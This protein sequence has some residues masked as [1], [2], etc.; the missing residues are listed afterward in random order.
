MVLKSISSPLFD[1]YFPTQII[2][3]NFYKD[4]VHQ[5]GILKC[6]SSNKC[7]KALQNIIQ[8]DMF[9]RGRCMDCRFILSRSYDE[10]CADVTEELSLMYKITDYLLRVLQ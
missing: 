6:T 2:I 4:Y 9:Y 1:L 10:L 7:I 8:P 5:I 3:Y